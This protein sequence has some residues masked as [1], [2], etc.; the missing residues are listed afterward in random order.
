[1]VHAKSWHIVEIAIRLE[2]YEEALTSDA[3]AAHILECIEDSAIDQHGNYLDDKKLNL[4]LRPA[5]LRS[6]SLDRA[7]T[8]KAAL[9]KLTEVLSVVVFASYCVPHGTS[10]IGKKFEP[11]LAKAFMSHITAACSATLCKAKGLFKGMYNERIRIGGGVRWGIEHEQ[12]EQLNRLGVVSVRDNFIRP[13]VTNKYSEKSTKKALRATKDPQDVA[14]ITVE[15]AART[16]VGGPLTSKTYILEGDGAIVL[17]A[18]EHISSLK[19]KFLGGTDGFNFISLVEKADEAAA[20][21]AEVMVSTNTI[22][23]LLLLFYTAHIVI[24]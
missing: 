4:G 12:A 2:L 13:C 21:M 1:M 23:L 20:I 10:S 15:L 11:G 24:Y 16:D 17:I 9:T 18:D 14:K 7:S 5:N 19:E 22:A 3:I 6:V 8:N